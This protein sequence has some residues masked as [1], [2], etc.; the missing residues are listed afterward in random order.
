[1]CWCWETAREAGAPSSVIDNR[2]LEAYI[3]ELEALRVHGQD[4][5]EQFPEIASRL[6]IGPRASRDAHVE[7]VV[8]SSAFLAARLRRLLEVD[9]AE[10]PLS[11]LSVLAPALIEPVPSLGVMQF[12]GGTE[13]QAVPANSRFDADLGGSPVCFSTCVP[14]EATPIT[15][16]TSRVEAGAGHVDGVALAIESGATADPWL[17][18]LGSDPRTGSA[19]IDA[20]DEALER[21]EV[22][23]PNGE[24]ISVPKTAIRIHGF[25]NAD[26]TLPVRPATHA[27]HRLLVEFLV[28]PDRFRFVSLRG[29]RLT[30]GSQLRLLFRRRLPLASPFSTELIKANCVPVVNLWRAPGTP[31]EVTGREL[32]YPVKVDALRYRTVECHSVES[33]DLHQ[34]DMTRPQRIDP[35]VAVGRIQESQVRWG[36]R[37]NLARHGGEVLLYFRGLDYGTLGRTRIMATPRVLASNRDIAS[38]VSSGTSL[39]PLDGMGAWRGVMQVTPTEYRHPLVSEDQM[40]TLV[41]YLHSSMVGLMQESRRGALRHFLKSFPGGSEASWIDG[42]GTAS[43]EPVTVL[44]Q[45][46]PQSGVSVRVRYDSLSHPLTSRAMVRRVLARLLDGQRG[47]N[48]VEELRLDV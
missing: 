6:D 29:F 30:R 22:W 15:M 46:Q 43:L 2:L 5:A 44:R 4:F 21:V 48:R 39:A 3:A 31:I 28:F 20:I 45:G 13:A 12:A 26:A 24:R 9:A 18:Y 7:R 17:L 47:L 36:V 33:V 23:R 25:D 38:Y 32:E 40:R 41:G 10:L 37:R 11:I 19:L 35:I 14:I 1:M 8:E 42:L 34:S 27:S 16:R